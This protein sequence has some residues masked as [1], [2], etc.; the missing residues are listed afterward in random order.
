MHARTY[1][2]IHTRAHDM[3]LEAIKMD[4]I[5]LTLLQSFLES[6]I[7]LHMCTP[8][9]TLTER[10]DAGRRAIDLQ[11]AYSQPCWVQEGNNRVPDLEHS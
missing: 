10:E 4:K 6:H 5:S 2:K 7:I 8:R 3:S 9:E 1:I 11:A